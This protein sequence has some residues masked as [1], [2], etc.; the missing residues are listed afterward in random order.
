LNS[1][2]KIDSK[3]VDIEEVRRALHLFAFLDP[4]DVVEV[5]LP[6]SSKGTISGYFDNREKLV[7][8]IADV[9]GRFH[10]SCYFTLNSVRPDLLARSVNRL[11]YY[12]RSTTKDK[13]IRHRS[14]LLVDIDPNR[15]EGIPTTDPEHES[16]IRLAKRVSN[17]LGAQ[18]WPEGIVVDSGNG[19][20]VLYRINLPNDEF[21]ANLVQR[22]LK[23][24]AQQYGGAAMDIDISVFNASR[25]CKIPGTLAIKGDGTVE[26]PHRL[27]RILSTPTVLTV[28][29][30]QLMATAVPLDGH[31]RIVSGGRKNH[32]D[33]FDLDAVLR[34]YG[35]DFKKT[36]WKGGSKYVFETCPNNPD[37]KRTFCITQQPN[38]GGISAKC[39]HASC[40]GFDWRA[41]RALRQA[42]HNHGGNGNNGFKSSRNKTKLDSH[43][44]VPPEFSE[45]ALALRFTKLHGGNL[46]Y[47]ASTGK[48]NRW[49]GQQWLQDDTLAIFDLGREV[50]REA[51]DQCPKPG[52][53]RQIAKAST[54]AAI[55]RL[56]RADRRHAMTVEQWDG[57]PWKLNTPSGI[58]DLRTGEISE[59]RREDYCTKITGS[60][61]A[62]EEPKLWVRFL[63]RVTDGNVDLQEFLQ[64]MFGYSLTGCTKEHALFFFYGL[65]KNGKSVFVLTL[66]AIA[67]EYAKS[68]P[69]ETFTES[70]IYQHPTDR[71][72]LVG[73]RLVTAV[74][75]EDGRR[76]AESKIKSMTGGDKISARFMRQDFFDY[77]PQFKLIIAGNHKPGLRTVDEAMR[78]RLHLIPFT[79]TISEKE[80]DRDL[81]EK[82]RAEWPRI[83]GWGIEGCLQWQRR[84]LD[85]PESVRAATE[86]Y[87]A[88]EDLLG[89]WLEERAVLG[90]QYSTP[91]S[92][93]YKDWKTWTEERNEHAGSN[94]RFSQGLQDRGF[95]IDSTR[96]ANMFIGIALR[97]DVRS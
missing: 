9:S 65:G 36:P 89:R 13:D 47:T 71:A 14:W 53:A 93:L 25:I 12:S 6:G 92:V 18:G 7:Q 97:Q 23:A 10:A 3:Q 45:D 51:A 59:H 62:Y 66:S 29:S 75:V 27:A 96:T 21:S 33:N 32:N 17:E 87:F 86:Q 43:E 37:H 2:I 82:L 67:G 40:E 34:S 22:V 35:D 74:E 11:T 38:G 95:R 52:I 64:R 76:W 39:L 88:A 20:H 19:A 56:A 61:V 15:P 77:V 55:E 57:D 90:V 31:L 24:L 26:R 94:K 54:V 58:V 73:A 63:D 49:T 48:W 50:S 1:S 30:D 16:A 84:G 81:S 72:G 41:Y 85:P 69:I 80:C 4:D 8:A 60:G 46:R 83:L 79:V 68:A 5:R 91:S 42:H 28:T 44:A 78:R 70:K